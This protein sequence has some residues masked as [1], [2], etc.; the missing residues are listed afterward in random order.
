MLGKAL[1]DIE[2][3]MWVYHTLLKGDTRWEMKETQKLP[4][5]WCM[6][7]S[8]WEYGSMNVRVRKSCDPQSYP[9]SGVRR[10]I[11][12]KYGF[13][14]EELMYMEMVG[15]KGMPQLTY[16]PF[17]CFW[18]ANR[19]FPYSWDIISFSFPIFRFFVSLI[20]FFK[21]KTALLVML[22]YF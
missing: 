3:T 15:W 14:S 11:W 7:K 9:N 21:R 2:I 6:G 13:R 12:T 10:R 4:Q 19:E 20:H 5:F 18:L 1:E 22:P 8:V 16:F 17:I